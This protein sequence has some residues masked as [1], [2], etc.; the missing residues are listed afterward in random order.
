MNTVSVRFK[1]ENDLRLAGE[2]SIEDALTRSC[3]ALVMR[4][5]TKSL[6]SQVETYKAANSMICA[7]GSALHGI[8]LLG[9]GLGDVHI[10]DRRPGKRMAE[11]L[12]VPR[13]ASVSYHDCIEGPVHGVYHRGRPQ[14]VHS[15]AVLEFDKIM[16]KLSA[17]I[18]DLIILGRRQLNEIVNRDIDEWCKNAP[19]LHR[20]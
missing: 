15:L 16:L 17:I 19:R 1:S 3:R 8:Q 9:R 20:K 5:E 12:R 14:T 13:C 18:G 7:E 6:S 10:I 4:P 2:K 11:H